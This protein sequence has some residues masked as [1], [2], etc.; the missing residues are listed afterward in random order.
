MTKSKYPPYPGS[1][2]DYAVKHSASMA[3]VRPNKAICIYCHCQ[4]AKENDI[5]HK[6]DCPAIMPAI[7][8]DIRKI[9]AE[10]HADNATYAAKRL[11]AVALVELERSYEKDPARVIKSYGT[12]LLQ[13]FDHFAA[14]PRVPHERGK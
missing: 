3:L 1:N 9:A 13:V 5:Q 4:A 7:D 11:L 10:L 12:E 2:W 8:L 14:T 6:P